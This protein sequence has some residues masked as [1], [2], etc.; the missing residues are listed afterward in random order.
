MSQ[1][2]PSVQFP[3]EHCTAAEHGCPFGFF[4]HEP[5]P[6]VFGATQ[7]ASDEHELLQ[8]P[9]L[10]TN[11]PHVY[12]V[13]RPPPSELGGLAPRLRPVLRYL[14]QGE[15]DKEIVAKLKLSRHTV[16]RYAQVIYRELDVHSRGELMATY[17][18]R[19]VNQ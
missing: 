15:A 18:R 19:T 17:A 14:L 10:H 16:H 13:P 3:D 9:L 6:Q 7:S 5:F 1:Q 12:H 2:T 11:A 8:L 4:P